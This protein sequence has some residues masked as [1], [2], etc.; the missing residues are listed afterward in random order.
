MPW[1]GEDK[2][3]YLDWALIFRG[4]PARKRQIKKRGLAA[5]HV[6]KKKIPKSLARPVVNAGAGD[7]EK[8]EVS[9]MKQKKQFTFKYAIFAATLLIGTLLFLIG[10]LSDSNRHFGIP[11]AL[12][13]IQYGI[14]GQLAPELNLSDWIDANGKKTEPIRL[15]DHR[16]KVIYLYFWQDW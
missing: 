13:N 5:L 1:R 7:I 16:G 6:K 3:D 8:V 11:V 15:S 2:I 10:G 4:K 9:P 12:A 14:L